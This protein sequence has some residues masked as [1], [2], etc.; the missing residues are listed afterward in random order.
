MDTA[1]VVPAVH[2]RGRGGQAARRPVPLQRHLP[3]GERVAGLHRAAQRARRPGRAR[4]VRRDQHVDLRGQAVPRRLLRGRRSASPTTRR[5]SRRPGLDPESPPQDVGRAS[6]TRATSSRPAGKIPIGGGVKDGFLGEWYLVQG[7]TQN[8]DTPTDAL[9]LFIGNLDWNAPEV[10]RALGQARGAQE[11]RLLQRR[12]RLAGA[13]PGH[14]AVRHR[15]GVDVLQHDAGAAELTEE[16]RRRQRRLHGHAGVRHRRDGGQADHRHAGL[17]HPEQGQEPRAGR[18][19]SSSSCTSPSS[20]QAMWTPS[21]Q[22]PANTDFDELDDRRPAAQERA[23][24]TGSPA[25]Q[26]RVHRRPDADAVLDRRDVRRL[27]EDPRRQH[28]RRGGGQARREVTEKWKKQNPDM[29]EN[30]TTWGQD[31]ELSQRA[32]GPFL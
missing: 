19:S 17:R 31:L 2:E 30:Y 26:R 24:R 25:T 12:R 11:V 6:S 1:N 15:Q 29:V 3:H 16:A 22:I 21:K 8:L 20:V 5:T 32:A 9:N 4:R 7:L 14:P 27:A 10:P 23:T 13:L 18:G 28:D